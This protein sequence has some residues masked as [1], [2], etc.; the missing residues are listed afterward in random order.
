MIQGS[1][2]EFF[3][4]GEYNGS[5]YYSSRSNDRL[6]FDDANSRAAELGGQLAVITS[7]GEQDFIVNGIY[8]NDPDFSVDNNRWLSH[9]I[10]LEFDKDDDTPVWEWTN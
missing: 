4:L 9:W 8:N 7:S 10:G 1:K 3:Y 5:K 2:S 6:Q